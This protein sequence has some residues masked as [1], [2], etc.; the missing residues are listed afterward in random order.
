MPASFNLETTIKESIAPTRGRTATPS[1]KGT[2][3]LI[4]LAVAK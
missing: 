2:T 3:A 1:D 4:K